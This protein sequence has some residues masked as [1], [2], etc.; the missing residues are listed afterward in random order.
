MVAAMAT[1][2]GPAASLA[3]LTELSDDVAGWLRQTSGYRGVFVLVDEGEATSRLIT[4][5]ET[6]EDELAARR[7]RGAMRDRLL[8]MAGLE[9]VS[10]EVYGVPG[11]EYV[12]G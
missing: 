9:I 7:A 5:W 8:A 2:S 11:H 1:I 10:F 6:P 3:T 12:P 4:L